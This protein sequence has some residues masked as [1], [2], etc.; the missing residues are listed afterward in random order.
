MG[1]FSYYRN[2]FT[3]A[4]KHS[5]ENFDTIS[6]AIGILAPVV[7]HL[8]PQ[9]EKNASY[10]RLGWEI[11]VYGLLC[12]FVL[13]VVRA[14]YELHLEEVAKRATAEAETKNLK[15]QPGG[16]QIWLEVETPSLGDGY[17]LSL[18]NTEGGTATNIQLAG[19]QGQ[20]HSSEPSEIIPRLYA[21]E[22]R[23]VAP[24][25]VGQSSVKQFPSVSDYP[26]VDIVLQE[27]SQ[28]PLVAVVN[29][30]DGTGKKYRARFKIEYD[31]KYREPKILR[32]DWGLAP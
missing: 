2:V 12:L 32:L 18:K 8:D 19:I 3:N 31:L 6:L 11:P 10:I 20:K 24:E 14:P 7:F 1:F 23:M 16:P 15:E 25:I 27:A 30:E 26:A 13:R 22:E 29:Y 5:W 28:Q 17:Q 4:F 9:L 21:N